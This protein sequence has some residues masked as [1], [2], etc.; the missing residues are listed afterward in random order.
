M[1]VLIIVQNR[2]GA[3]V[4]RDLARKLAEEHEARKLL[5]AEILKKRARRP[6]ISILD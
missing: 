4:R 2:R 6:R 5:E 3:K 1:C